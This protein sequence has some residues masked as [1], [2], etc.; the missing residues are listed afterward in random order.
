MK[1][2][3]YI[4]CDD[5]RTEIGNKVS[6]MG[7]FNERIIINAPSNIKWPLPMRLGIYVRIS[8]DEGEER[9][10][11]FTFV[12]KLKGD[13]IVE[14]KGVMPS[15]NESTSN[16]AIRGDGVPVEP[17]DIGFELTL[18]KNNKQVFQK[19]IRNAIVVQAA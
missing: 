18:L 4:F 3:E 12:L 13:T 9:P 14:V 6:L 1:L 2:R 5:I 8:F 10:D 17:G 16:L 15:I 19:E 7:I 11:E